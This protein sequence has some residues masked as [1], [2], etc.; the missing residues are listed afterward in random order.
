M[1]QA[2]SIFESLEDLLIREQFIQSCSTD[3]ALF[4]KERVPKSVAEMTKLAEQ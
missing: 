1:A 3:T 4:L 2:G